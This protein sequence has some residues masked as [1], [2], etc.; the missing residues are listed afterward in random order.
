MLRTL[1]LLVFTLPTVAL[2]DS[3]TELPIQGVLTDDAGFPIDGVVDIRLALYTLPEG[4]TPVFAEDTVVN[5]NQGHFVAYLGR[6]ETLD[7]S[8]ARDNSSLYLGITVEDDSEMA[9]IP[10]A[11]TA[12][13]GW[14]DYSGNAETLDGFDLDGVIGEV[15]ISLGEDLHDRYLDSEAVSAMGNSEGGNPLNHSRYTDAAAL[16]MSGASNFLNPLNHER[17]TEPEA[18]AA[19]GNVRD[20]NAYAHERYDD[21]NVVAALGEIGVANPYAHNRFTDAEAVAAMGA[22]GNDNPLAHNRYTDTDA[23][24]AVARD[25]RYVS[26]TGDVLD[27]NLTFT[28]VLKDD[29]SPFSVHLIKRRFWR[30]SEGIHFQMPD[31]SV[32]VTP[33]SDGVAITTGAVRYRPSGSVEGDGILYFN[34]EDQPTY[35][36]NLLH[37]EDDVARS[38]YYIGTDGGNNK[39]AIWGNDD[40]ST[41]EIAREGVSGVPIPVNSQFAMMC[42]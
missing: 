25:D 27:G 23:V 8:I 9:R 6:V 26:N 24:N 29:N 30:S 37:W 28:G 31:G 3:P 16:A 17:F 13:A 15:E 40:T 18:R 21:G 35:A 33:I 34:I 1:A 42:F 19:M 10:I 38:G 22:V 20:D 5:A 36:C 12:F 41:F 14:A 2:A 11:T 4:T 32:T 39:V 7:W